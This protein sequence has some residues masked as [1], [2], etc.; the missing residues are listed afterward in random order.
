[1]STSEHDR[2]SNSVEKPV[3]IMVTSENCFSETGVLSNSVEIPRGIM[4]MNRNGL[5]KQLD[6]S[7]IKGKGKVT[8]MMLHPVV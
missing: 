1:L 8:N 6:S 4:V 2:W 3:E 7:P 5:R